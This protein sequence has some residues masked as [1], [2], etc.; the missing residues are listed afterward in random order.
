MT[1]PLL[2]FP[3]VTVEICTTSNYHPPPNVWADAI[4]ADGLQIVT[5]GE[6]YWDV[7]TFVTV[8]QT[9]P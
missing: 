6:A 5:V 2:Q 7:I 9:R 8:E 1:T 3:E 4:L